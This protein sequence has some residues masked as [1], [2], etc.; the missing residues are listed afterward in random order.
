MEGVYLCGG[1]VEKKGMRS[2]IGCLFVG[3]LSRVE[4]IF[5]RSLG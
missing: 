2:F 5:F 4:G 3:G 1:G